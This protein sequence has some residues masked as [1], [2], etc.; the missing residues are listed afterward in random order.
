[1][2]GAGDLATLSVI[3]VTTGIQCGQSCPH[4]AFS[5]RSHGALDSR[6]RGND[7]EAGTKRLD[8]EWHPLFLLP[9]A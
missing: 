2:L 5:G 7:G 6:L 3:P 8:K 9:R 1:M 4:E